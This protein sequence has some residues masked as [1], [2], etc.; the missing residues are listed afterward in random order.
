VSLA[1]GV[2][3]SQLRR[4]S[5]TSVRW[6]RAMPSPV[7]RTGRGLTALAFDRGFP[8][9]YRQEV[10]GFFANVGCVLEIAEHKFDAFTA[11]YS[12]SHGYHA[13]ATLAGAASKL[14]L[15]RK[16]ALAAAAHALADGIVAWREGETALVHLLNEAATPRGIAASVMVSM[17]QAGYRRIVEEGLRS[18]MARARKN[19]KR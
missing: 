2:P 19:A 1:A 17:D 11:A 3:L 13:L 16:T 18:G 4:Q 9:N 5:G 15:D 8:R 14:G 6:A 10:K 12:C 7:C